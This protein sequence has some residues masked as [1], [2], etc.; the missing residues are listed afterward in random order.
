MK[1]R[2]YGVG[3]GPGDPGL[4]TSRAMGL[5]STCDV[6][7]YPVGYVGEDSTALGIIRNAIDLDGRDLR[8]FVFSMSPN[9]E[10]WVSGHED[11]VERLC[12]ILSEG[13]D[14][15]MGVLGDVAVYST[16]MYIR[17][18]VV[19]RGF[20]V[21]VVPGVPSFCHGAAMAGLPLALR[22]EG[23]AVVPMAKGNEDL[24]SD[25]LDRF[26]NIVVM[27]A[28][29][30]VDKVRDM[31][32]SKGIP[33]SAATVVCNVGMADQYIGPLDGD[34]EYGYFTTILIKKN[35]EEKE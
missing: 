20:E 3:L 8:E 4:I 23:L 15:V 22:D 25:A 29:R 27:K 17:E 21:E 13:K 35:Q 10:D 28:R 32:E 31:M 16:F 30:S 11:N 24:L 26:D 9:H 5:L 14:V 34:R 2:L 33:A 7:A 12:A 18:A 19:S 6:I 1:G